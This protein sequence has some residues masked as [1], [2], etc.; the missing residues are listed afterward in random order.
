MSANHKCPIR[1]CG[2][3]VDPDRLMCH[4]HWRMV[5]LPL[6]KTIWRL[7]SN[8]RPKSGHAEACQSAIEQVEAVGK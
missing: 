4:G 3:R 1:G 8:G 2:S 6:Q 5:P 7:W